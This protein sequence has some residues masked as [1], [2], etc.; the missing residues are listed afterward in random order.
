ML[1]PALIPLLFQTGRGLGNT[2]FV[3]LWLV[4]LG[5]CLKQRIWKAPAWSASGILWLIFLAWGTYSAAVSIAPESSL[6]SWLRY[7]LIGSLFFLTVRVMQYADMP[8]IDWLLRGI[9]WIGLLS[10]GWLLGHTLLTYDI[11][12]FKP[13]F[14]LRGLVPAYL[15]PFVLYLISCRMTGTVRIVTM[16][17]YSVVLAVLL[18][19]ANSLTELLA[20]AAALSV[21]I[22]M[23]IATLRARLGLLVC[24]LAAV[25]ALILVFDPAGKLLLS[26]EETPAGQ[27][28]QGDWLQLAD[29]L[30]SQRTLIWRQAVAMPPPLPWLGVGPGNVSAYPPVQLGERGSVKH[31]HNL[32]LDVWYE[33]GFVGLALYLALLWS[34]FRVALRHRNPLSRPVLFAVTAAILSASL[35][36]QSYRSYHL[37]LFLPFVFALFGSA[38]GTRISRRRV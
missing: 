14:N 5:I 16:G 30:S 6:E 2:G 38:P 19:H 9:G 37:A 33:I 28:Q 18:V 32:L 36:E 8:D 25:V 27:S 20:L 10:F 4:M 29:R 15:S 13:E 12:G 7:G 11:P 3:L 21:L 24:M 22:V 23:R 1:A 34:Q 26:T 35:I 17:V 31:L